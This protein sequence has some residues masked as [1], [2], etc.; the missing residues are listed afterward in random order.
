MHFSTATAVMLRLCTERPDADIAMPG[1]IFLWAWRL[2][3][4]DVEAGYSGEQIMF[5]RRVLGVDG[6]VF[7]VLFIY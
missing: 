2:C 3:L 1:L 7:I 5:L 6:I 4:Y